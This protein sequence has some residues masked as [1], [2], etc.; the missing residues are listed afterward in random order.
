MVV[1][2]KGCRT[3]AMVAAALASGVFNMFDNIKDF[4]AA[5]ESK[6]M[7]DIGKVHQAYVAGYYESVLSY[8]A[9]DIPEVAEFLNRR[10][11]YINEH[12]KVA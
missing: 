11:Q 5:V 2:R 1:M 12:K 9:K 3:S 8:L 7:D 10:V 6:S 4:V